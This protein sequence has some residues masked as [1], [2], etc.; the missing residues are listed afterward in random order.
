[1][2]A[3]GFDQPTGDAGRIAVDLVFFELLGSGSCN[4]VGQNEVAAFGQT[5][6]GN[7]HDLDAVAFTEDALG[8]HFLGQVAVLHECSILLQKVSELVRAESDTALF[9][10]VLVA[11]SFLCVEEQ[12]VSIG[13]GGSGGRGVAISGSSLCQSVEHV[14]FIPT[15]FATSRP[16]N[17]PLRVST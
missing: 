14:I 1:M 4:G 13:L 9:G 12:G 16:V 8:D 7:L 11:Q 5:R 15:R 17:S 10:D 6:S 2:L 3:E